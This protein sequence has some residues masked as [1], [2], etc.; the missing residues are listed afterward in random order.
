MTNRRRILKVKHKFQDRLILEAILITFIFLNML[1]IGSFVALESIP[2][3][4]TLKYTLAIALSAGELGGL[5]FIYYFSLR[6]SHRIAGPVYMIERRLR[7]VG[8]GDLTV[9]LRLRKG[10]HFQDTSEILNECIADLRDKMEKIQL[11]VAKLK[12]DETLGAA[13]K[14]IVDELSAQVNVF[15]TDVQF[16]PEDT[17]T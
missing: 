12:Q 17:A 15:I 6:S 4:F 10:D 2:D 14:S 16:K 7:E 1:V 9:S 5:A 13:S 11:S 3:I 8:A